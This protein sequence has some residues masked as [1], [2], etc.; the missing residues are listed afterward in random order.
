MLKQYDCIA[1]KGEVK[2]GV[3]R[4]DAGREVYLRAYDTAMAELPRPSFA[5]DVPTSLGT[6]RAYGWTGSL[7][8]RE[9]VVLLPGRS[10]GVPMW[11]ENLSDLR[12]SGRTIIALDALGD[13]GMSVQTAPLNRFEDQGTWVEEALKG[14]GLNRVHMVGHSFGGATSAAHALQHPARVA[15]LALLEPVFVFRRP[16]ISM[17]FWALV[18]NLPVPKSWRDH[19]LSAIGGVSVDDV[20]TTTPISVMIE[21]GSEHFAAALPTPRRLNDG[22]WASLT[23]PVYVAIASH[24][25]MAG[26][27]PGAVRAR[28]IPHAMVDVWPHT[29]HSLPMQVHEAL[30]ARLNTFWDNAR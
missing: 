9:P 8:D 7:A 12:A 1:G 16:P 20:R 30:A 19:A 26:G 15:S 11:G 17:F 4:S 14:L 2:L 3:F 23:M 21:T 25:S 5:K 13:A 28:R 27:E 18:S 10:S 6:V 22:E 24:H 29:T